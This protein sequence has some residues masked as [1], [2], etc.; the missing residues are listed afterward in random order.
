MIIVRSD[1]LSWG[2][3]VRWYFAWNTIVSPDNR[4]VVASIG[5]YPADYAIIRHWV[6]LC[7]VIQLLWATHCTSLRSG[8]CTQTWAFHCW[9]PKNS[10]S[11]QSYNKSVTSHIKATQQNLTNTHTRNPR[12]SCQSPQ[13]TA[14]IPC[15]RKRQLDNVIYFDANIDA[16]CW[17]AVM[18]SATGHDPALV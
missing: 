9:W 15:Y 11:T 5:S 4:T 7:N 6:T 1:E 16:D 12:R 17:T 8:G 14:V 18:R 2:N 10:S 3:W 13:R